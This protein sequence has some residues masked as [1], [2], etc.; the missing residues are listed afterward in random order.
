MI[1]YVM[2]VVKIVLYLPTEYNVSVA[3]WHPYLSLYLSDH[4]KLH[5]II[6]I[7]L[8]LQSYGWCE[9]RDHSDPINVLQ[10]SSCNLL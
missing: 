9:S 3:L 8:L 5:A 6:R 2:V 10:P 4:S 1:L 7:L